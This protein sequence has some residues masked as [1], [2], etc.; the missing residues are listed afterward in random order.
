MT[1]IADKLTISPDLSI[2]KT[3]T[4]RICVAMPHL[5][6]VSET[7][8]KAHLTLLPGNISI[9]HG[10]YATWT[11][12]GHC[13][14]GTNQSKLVRRLRRWHRQ[15]FR[16]H[17]EKVRGRVLAEHLKSEQCQVVLVEFATTAVDVVEACWE[18]R[19]PL[20]VHFHG[21]DAYSKQVL[22]KNGERYRD[23][24]QYASA[25][26]GVSR[27]MCR[28][29]V[30]LGAPENKV[31]YLCYGVDT[32]Q[33]HNA[34]PDHAGMNFLAVGRFVAKKAPQV[35]IRS[36]AKVLEQLPS[37]RLRMVG[38]GEL[39]AECKELTQKLGIQKNVDFLGW[40]NPSE[41]QALM[42]ESRAFVQH[43]VVPE[44]GD[45]EG[46]PVVI[47]EAQASG[48]PVISTVHAG[49]P[50][51]VIHGETGLLVQE[52]DMQGMADAMIRLAQD[53]D[54]A[55]QMGRAARARVVSEFDQSSQIAKLAGILS[56]AIVRR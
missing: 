42:R 5:P 34:A 7:F 46:T 45:S 25:V 38:E 47:L 12:S 28:Q 2:C 31:H 49:I 35:T 15:W 29:L 27:H 10:P 36:F 54:L 51:V 19:V 52:H 48:L 41:I 22:E 39:W 24:F 30:S 32:K 18:A 4:P 26:I 43:S 1:L 56:E 3:G 6:T 40:R 9:L 17:W 11:E 8:I 44:S 21:Y 20:V 53:S 23:L 14:L 50:D 16:S 33:F 37:A 55:A 13:L